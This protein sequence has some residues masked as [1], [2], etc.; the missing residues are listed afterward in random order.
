MTRVKHD[1]L[2]YLLDIS[3]WWYIFILFYFFHFQENSQNALLVGATLETLLKF[4]N[5]IPL[6]YIFETKL[7]TTLIYK[8]CL[9]W[10]SENRFIGFNVQLIDCPQLCCCV[11]G[12][13]PDFIDN[14]WIKWC[15]IPGKKWLRLK[16]SPA[17]GTYLHDWTAD[18]FPWANYFSRLLL[19]TAENICFKF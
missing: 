19:N 3:D 12:N 4:L 17:W 1:V 5:W 9:E 16:T 14:Q 11:P 7:I 2:L 15:Q 18:S 13:A 10:V 6:G 8:V